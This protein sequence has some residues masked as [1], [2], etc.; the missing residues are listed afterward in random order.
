[1]SDGPA[2]Q[3]TFKRNG[4]INFFLRCLQALPASGTA[5]D[6]NRSVLLT[7]N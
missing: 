2:R 4:H 6:A 5:Q 3:T 1:M 7:L